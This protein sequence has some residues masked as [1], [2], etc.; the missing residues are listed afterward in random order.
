MKILIHQENLYSYRTGLFKALTKHGHDIQ[1]LTSNNT[2]KNEGCMS[3]EIKEFRS[4]SI[5]GLKWANFFT[6]QSFKGH[7]YIILLPNLRYLHVIF[8][9][10]ILSQK[11]LIFWGY[12]ES[13]NSWLINRMKRLLFRGSKYIIYNA[14]YQKKLPIKIQV[15]SIVANNTMFV[16]NSGPSHAKKISFL[17]V[18]RLQ[19][20]KRLDLL[21]ECFSEL[22]QF[23]NELILDI[24]GE[25]DEEFENL[26]R[27]VE[28][29]GIVKH[30][31]FHGKITNDIELGRLFGRAYAY[32][33][34][35]AIGL[36][37]QHSFAYGV[38]VVT[39]GD[40]FKGPEF[41]HM[42]NG[43]NCLL[44]DKSM[45]LYVALRKIIEP[46]INKQLSQ[47]AYSYHLANLSPE[48]MV[49]GFL[50]ALV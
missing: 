36:G 43:E 16:T 44:T 3:F 13:E 22:L 6:F 15:K 11:K 35:D 18:G 21:I 37:G 30:V 46:E 38:P 4:F 10:L 48:I 27:L 2:L 23:N 32:V 8:W 33:S 26:Q 49:T 19:K 47:G 29:K 24:V 20:R 14:D 7:D 25:G 1:I 50:K 40:G 42:R 9:T 45:T 31:N 39:A 5:C 41:V 34:P 17:Y 12:E 28:D